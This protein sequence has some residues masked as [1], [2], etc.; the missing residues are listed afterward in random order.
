MN[1]AQF[2]ALA[3]LLRRRP[4]NPSYMAAMDVFVHGAS[5][6]DAA[7]KHGIQYTTVA[8]S[9]ASF[10]DALRLCYTVITGEMPPGSADYAR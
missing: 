3:K 2:L 7:K 8:V 6:K 1:E 10:R 9:C 5:M 4:G